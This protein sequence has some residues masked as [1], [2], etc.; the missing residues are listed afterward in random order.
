MVIRQKIREI[1][2]KLYGFSSRQIVQIH[3]EGISAFYRKIKKAFRILCMEIFVPL[4]TYFNLDIPEA[5]YFNI[6]KSMKR[7]KQIVHRSH[8]GEDRAL[9]ATEKKAVAYYKKY[10]KHN[11]DAKNLFKWI[12]ANETLY[13]LLSVTDNF[14]ENID[15]CQKVEAYKHAMI[16][17][18][19]LDKLDI[20]FIPRSFVFGSIGIYE[21][22]DSYVRAG[23]LGLRPDKKLILL[24]DLNIAINNKCYLDYWHKYI[25]IITDP[26]LINLLSPLEELLISPIIFY[27]SFYEKTVI[28]YRALGIIR[29]QWVKEKRPPVLTL[30]DQDYERGW[31]CLRELGIP[32]NAW[33]VCLHAREAGWNDKDSQKE[34]FRNVDIKTYIPAI[35]AVVDAGGWVIRMGDSSMT[36]LPK[37]PQ[38]IDYAHS[39]VTS[40]WMDVFLSS[41]CRFFIATSSG[42]F[43]FAMAFGVPVVATNF[44]PGVSILY[45][46][47]R[48]DILIPRI[49]RSR[50]EN[51]A[52]SFQE[53][54]SPPISML[55]AQ[56]LY[57]RFDLEIIDNTPEE[58]KE[59]VVEMLERFEGTLIYNNEDKSLQAKFRSMT[60][61]CSDL[62]G[63]EKIPIGARI[64]R[65]FLYKHASLLREQKEANIL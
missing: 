34:R 29:D 37:L 50:K 16:K 17:K 3:K 60:E 54:L 41:Q 4:A 12:S 47:S 21:R 52:L 35:K 15:I 49:F 42:L 13:Y 48:Q 45:Y 30:K 5:H 20:E 51:R 56:N 7:Y 24:V 26:V 63:V 40:D 8:P 65:D 9:Q 2:L 1:F 64:G 55:G 61:Q 28:S 53:L 11:P 44:L 31:Q 36:P 14:R 27:M 6:C 62:Y 39:R 23:I 43:S 10:I 32:E 38:V 33:F 59:V 57:E 58:I 25:T 46:F 19:Q 22:L 18:N